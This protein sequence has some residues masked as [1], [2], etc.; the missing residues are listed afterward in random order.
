M[1]WILVLPLVG[2]ALAADIAVIDE[3]I[4]KVNGDIITRS[5]IERSRKQM[6]GELRGQKMNGQA[7]QKAMAER[8]PG[9]L[10]DR[11]DQLLLIQKGKELNINVESDITKQLAEMQRRSKV[12]D[13]EKF[14]AYVREQTGMSFEDFKNEMRNSMLTDRV[15]RQEIRVNVPRADVE[16][17]YAEHKEEF[18]REERVFLQEIFLS[19]DGKDEK[20]AALIEK[21]AKDLTA[22]AKKGEKF[23]SLARDNSDS[24]S[25]ENG[26]DLGGWKRGDL[27]KDIEAAVFDK[28]KNFIT[29]PMKRTGSPSGFLIL[30]VYEK[31]TA[32]QATYEEVEQEIQNR[33]MSGLFQ[34]KVRAYLTQLRESAFLEIKSGFVDTGAAPGKDTSWKDPAQLK[35]ETVTKEEV[36]TR[37]RRK[38]LLWAVPLPGTKTTGSSSSKKAKMP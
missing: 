17:Y 10:R 25:A 26:G 15:M 3:I 1:K 4:V 14:Q 8:E 29:E 18:K 7:L 24:Q 5:E 9:I 11:I 16:K 30:K 19:T 2:L 37:T 32:G 27:A 38:K 31:H 12:L 23:E 33:L 34:P 35:P 20:T 6:E 36:A 13:P 28:D 21:K 22:R